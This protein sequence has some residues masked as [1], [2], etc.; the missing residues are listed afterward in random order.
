MIVFFNPIVVICFTT[1]LTLFTSFSGQSSDIKRM[2]AEVDKFVRLLKDN[3][4]KGIFKM[5]YHSTSIP[6]ISNVEL[7]QHEVKK[8]SELIKHYSLSSIKN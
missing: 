6:K 7:R 3:D 1:L 5:T 4:E 2:Q 8:A